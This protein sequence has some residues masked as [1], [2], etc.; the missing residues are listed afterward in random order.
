M[1][2][3]SH[4]RDQQNGQMH[5]RQSEGIYDMYDHIQTVQSCANARSVPVQIVKIVSSWNSRR[6]LKTLVHHEG[7]AMIV[8]S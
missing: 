1:E 6:T 5:S 7:G 8:V 3:C 2:V 4:H